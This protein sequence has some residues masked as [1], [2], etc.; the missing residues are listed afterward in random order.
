MKSYQKNLAINSVPQVRFH[1][2]AVDPETEESV[3]AINSVPQVRFHL[4]HPGNLSFKILVF[5]LQLTQFPKSGFTNKN[6][7]SDSPIIPLAINSVPQVRFHPSSN[8][9]R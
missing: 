7:N 2:Q 3:L 9:A 6:K 5:F 1:L 8:M 4:H